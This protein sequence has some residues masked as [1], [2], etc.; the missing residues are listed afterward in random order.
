[1]TIPASRIIPIILPGQQ[2]ILRDI[3][4]KAIGT[5]EYPRAVLMARDREIEAV[6]RRDGTVRYLRHLT[7]TAREPAAPRREETYQSRST[8]IAQ[9]SI[10]AYRQPLSQGWVWALCLCRGRA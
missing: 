9:K 7:E 1:M 8:V 2:Y 5:V 6:V 10:G 4:D 3:H